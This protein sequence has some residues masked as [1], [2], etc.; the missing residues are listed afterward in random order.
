MAIE[1]VNSNLTLEAKIEQLNSMILELNG[2][3]E[4]GKFNKVELDDLNTTTFDSRAFLRDVLLGNDTSDYTDWTWVHDESGY[5]IW[6][7]AP[8]NYEYHASNELYFTDKLCENKGQ[9]TSA[10]LVSFDSIQ[11]FDDESGVGYTV[12]STEVADDDASSASL[13]AD[14]AD[15]LYI[16]HV[17]TFNGVTFEFDTRGSGYTLV[18]EYYDGS[19]GDGWSTFTPTDNTNEFLSDGLIEW[20]SSDVTGW[21]TSTINGVTTKYWIRISTSVT[22]V[23]TA[24]V[25]MI[26][27]NTSVLGLLALSSSEM[28]AESW[29]W[30]S[31]G[32]EAYVTIRNAGNA[33]YEGDYFITQ[34]SS[35]A[36]LENFFTSNQEFKIN[37][38]DSTYTA[39]ADGAENISFIESG[40][41][42]TNVHDAI[43]EAT[44]K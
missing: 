19:S 25:D 31:Y 38:K 21:A 18:F 26:T 10:T 28:L 3:L 37:H 16:G 30:C 40:W 27:S 7:I 29:K 33:S 1:R 44:T 6:K 32:G 5:S 24:V 12:I 15:Y 41:T 42:S 23:T 4:Q 43:I 9:A 2:K 39:P 35:A 17:S 20:T 34:T 22:P 11:T 14:T 13:M 8:D 36:N